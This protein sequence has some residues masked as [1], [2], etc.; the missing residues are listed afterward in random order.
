MLDFDALNT[1]LDN[2]QEVIFA[3]L[4]VYQEDH[5]NSLD[6]IKELVQQQDWGKLH[7]TVHTL[8]GILASFGEE[9]ATAAL[10]RVE[11][12]TLNK[13]A[14]KDEDLSV[15]YSEV[16]IINKQIDEALSAY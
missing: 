6:E 2:D 8:K 4:S 1:Y 12:N 10:E 11:Q 3:V 5:G 16:K 9:T 7:F 14:P 13:L 15:I